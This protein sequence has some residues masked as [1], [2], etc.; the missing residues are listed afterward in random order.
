[1]I[2]ILK[3]DPNTEEVAE[4]LRASGVVVIENFLSDDEV[5][6]ILDQLSGAIDKIPIAGDEFT[7]RRSQV[8]ST[9]VKRSER[10]REFL[11]SELY[12]STVNSILGDNCETWR[13]SASSLMS[14]FEGG[15]PQVMHRDED[16]YRTWVDRSPESPSYLLSSILAMTD[17]TLEN[18]ATRFV[19]DSH[20]QKIDT[21]HNPQIE[22]PAEMP[23]G[24]LAFWLG[25]TLHGLGVNTTAKP[26][27]GLISISAVGWLR[28]EENFYGSV[29]QDL[30]REYPERLQQM[31]GWQAHGDMGGYIPGRDPNN[32]LKPLD[33]S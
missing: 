29:P 11:V 2:P 26:R 22:V 10:Y 25:S 7:G 6:L 13:L 24:S 33:L 9:V 3:S 17:F 14:V 30:A 32:Q 31:L 5:D 28:Q 18:G 27:R 23:K 21:A 8:I 19:P 12:Q 20:L 16:L 15:Q 4:S 1:M